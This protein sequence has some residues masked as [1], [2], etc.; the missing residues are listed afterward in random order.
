[1]ISKI[2]MKNTFRMK[3]CDFLKIA[4]SLGR[5]WPPSKNQRETEYS[6]CTCWKTES[7]HFCPRFHASAGEF[8]KL[9]SEQHLKK[10]SVTCSCQNGQKTQPA[11]SK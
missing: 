5:F 8:Q 11:N 4:H 1:M 3:L 7:N 6:V 9:L 2:W 10:N